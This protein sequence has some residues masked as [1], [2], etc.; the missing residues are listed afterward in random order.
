MVKGTIGSKIIGQEGSGNKPL[1]KE[2]SDKKGRI[3]TPLD[4]QIIV[5]LE[6]YAF[7]C[8]IPKTH[9]MADIIEYWM[10]D[11]KF[12]ENWY[13]RYQD[14][15]KDIVFTTVNGENGFYLTDREG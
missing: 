9:L 5:A 10:K 13:K 6:E 11:R 8:G 4:K 15:R 3:N 12:L 2:R 14:R 1:R 7:A